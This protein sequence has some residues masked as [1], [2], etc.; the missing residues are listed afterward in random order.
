MWNTIWGRLTE[1]CSIHQEGAQGRPRTTL[2]H[3]ESLVPRAKVWTGPSYPQC[4]RSC[5]RATEGTSSPSWWPWWPRARPTLSRP[6]SGGAGT[7][8]WAAAFAP[9]GLDA[10]AL[11]SWVLRGR[12]HP[13]SSSTPQACFVLWDSPPPRLPSAAL[14]IACPWVCK[15]HLF[16]CQLG[17]TVTPRWQS[18]GSKATFKTASREPRGARRL[19]APGCG[20]TG[21][22]LRSQHNSRHLP[23][24]FP[25]RF[26][27]FKL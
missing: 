3:V 18:R 15:G 5:W 23:L 6:H 7:S 11:P 4:H 21:H 20:H 2:L 17:S 10:V 12:R 13:L 1:L 25:D 9:I 14:G 24:V 27:W 19:L 26:L 8:L 22:N 16:L